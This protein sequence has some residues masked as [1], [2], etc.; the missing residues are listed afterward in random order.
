MRNIFQGDVSQLPFVWTRG[1]AARETLRYLDRKGINADQLVSTAE[2]SRAQLTENPSGVSAVSQHRFLEL[3]AAETDD[4]LLGLHVA[5][6]MDLR[7]L[8]LLFYLAASSATVGEALEQLAQYAA[9]T[10]EEIRLEILPKEGE[11]VLYF[12]RVLAVDQPVCQ[13][14]ELAALGLIRALRKVTNRDFSPSR[15]GFTHARNSG[16]REIHRMLRCPV[17]FVQAVDGWVLPQRIMEL[18]IVSEDS[19]LLQILE[20]HAD[21]ILSEKHTV[22]G[23]RDLVEDRLIRLLPN[24]RTQAAVIAEQLGMSERSFRRRLSEEGANFGE[25]VDRLRHRLALHYL[26]DK[27]VSLKQIAWLLGYSELGAF[28]HAF[29]RWT[30]TSPGQ[31]RKRSAS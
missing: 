20:A 30:G 4:P 21:E 14:S 12:H 22:T 10:T 25:V 27:R 31:V 5:A 11:T 8:G 2:L 18:P 28:N 19:H 13:Q 9:T 6:E 1:I 24:G 17:E 15:I 23:L 26:E 16:L 3:A 7:E 29:K